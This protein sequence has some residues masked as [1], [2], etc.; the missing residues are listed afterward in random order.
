LVLDDGSRRRFCTEVHTEVPTEVLDEGS[1][2]RFPRRFST[3]VPTE[4][5]DEG[6]TGSVRNFVCEAG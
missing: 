2:G 3:K 5:L 6:S 4:V 1:P